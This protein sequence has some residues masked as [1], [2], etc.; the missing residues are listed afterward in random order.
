MAE[1]NQAITPSP[2][3]SNQ[4]ERLRK[5]IGKSRDI[6]LAEIAR[7]EKKFDIAHPKRKP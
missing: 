5:E 6:L 3:L 7:L 1:N 4:H 2:K